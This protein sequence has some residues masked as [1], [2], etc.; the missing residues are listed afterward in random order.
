M[1]ESSSFCDSRTT[2]QGPER[3][4]QVR[5][6]QLGSPAAKATVA[7]VEESSIHRCDFDVTASWL[8]FIGSC[9]RIVNA[10]SNTSTLPSPGVGRPNWIRVRNGT[11]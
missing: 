1:A 3:G 6:I 2:G 11:G 10:T 7:V 8:M 4:L 5:R 9:P